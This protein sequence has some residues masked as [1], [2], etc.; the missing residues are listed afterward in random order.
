MTHKPAM[1]W[2]FRM[3]GK[4]PNG[5]VQTTED[6]QILMSFFDKEGEDGIG[7]IRSR[8]DAR[9]LARRILQCLEKTK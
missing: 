7:I 1:M 8:R 5:Y 4:Y 2:A 3:P 9:L 6:N